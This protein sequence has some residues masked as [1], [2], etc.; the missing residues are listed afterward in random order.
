MKE[1]KTRKLVCN[2][3]GKVL[4]AGKDYYSKKVTKAGTEEA[5]HRTYVCKEAKD[6][7]KRGYNIEDTQIALNVDKSVKCNLLDMDISSIVDNKPSMRINTHEPARIGVIKT[8][9]DVDKFVESILHDNMLEDKR[10]G[11]YE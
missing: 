11:I 3:T 6:L 2:I 5:L 4:F 8:D 10:K 7:L 1:K 9:P